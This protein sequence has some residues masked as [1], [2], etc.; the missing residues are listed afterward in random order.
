MLASRFVQEIISMYSAADF[1]FWT[2]L[3][4][5]KHFNNLWFFWPNGTFPPP[6]SKRPVFYEV[7]PWKIPESIDSLERYL[8]WE[9]LWHFRTYCVYLDIDISGYLQ[10]VTNA[11]LSTVSD[12]VTQN[13]ATMTSHFYVN[14]SNVETTG[15]NYEGTLF[16]DRFSPDNKRLIELEW[17]ESLAYTLNFINLHNTPAWDGG[18]TVTNPFPTSGELYDIHVGGTGYE[19]IT[20]IPENG[21]YTYTAYTPDSVYLKLN[22]AAFFENN[23]Q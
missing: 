10:E 14:N 2:P 9:A 21:S 8:I 12:T 16:F 5:R 4:V 7:I 1:R 11:Y 23:D 19:L 18:N 20:T 13:A 22:T 3:D 17:L 6:L 15:F